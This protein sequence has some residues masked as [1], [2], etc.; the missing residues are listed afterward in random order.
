MRIIQCDRC[1]HDGG[2]PKGELHEVAITY[3]PS[4]DNSGSDVIDLL[5]NVDLCGKCK[6]SLRSLVKQFLAESK[7]NNK[8]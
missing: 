1:G 4:E 7:D 2:S 6:N 8:K 3:W 5:P